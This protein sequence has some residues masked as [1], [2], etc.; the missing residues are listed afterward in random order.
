MG[1]NNGEVN[2]NGNGNSHYDPDDEK[3]PFTEKE[4]VNG[5]DIQTDKRESPHSSVTPRAEEDEG[6]LKKL[7]SDAIYREKYWIS[8]GIMWSFFVLGWTIGQF[9]PSLLDLRIITST[10]LKQASA[11]MTGH[12][13]G[14]LIGSI[15]MGIIFDKMRKEKTFSVAWSVVAMTVVLAVIPWCYIYELMVAMHVFKGLA[16]G[17]LDTTGN[18]LLISLWRADGKSFLQSIHFAFAIGG[19]ISPFVTG[20]FLAP[21]NNTNTN[22][23]SEIIGNT[24]L[25]NYTNNATTSNSG[26]FPWTESRLYVPYSIAAFLALTA[27]VPLFVLACTSKRPSDVKSVKSVSSVD[28]DIDEE[29]N[30]QRLSFGMKATVLIILMVFLGIY[31]AME[32]G[33]NSFLATF[34]VSKLK[35]TKYMASIVTAVFWISYTIARFIGIF[36]ARIFKPVKLIFILTVLVILGFLGFFLSAQFKFYEG[37]WISSGVVGLAMSMIFPLVFAWTE[38]SILPVTGLVASLFLIAASLGSMINPIVLGFLMDNSSP[39]WLAY[40][41]LGESIINLMVLCLAWT[42][43]SRITLPKNTFREVKIEIRSEDPDEIEYRSI[44]AESE[45]NEDRL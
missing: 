31:C 45:L 35:W 25:A 3:T 43:A 4:E 5:N 41:M 22:T 20:P 23:T 19:A 42:V 17:G 24:S 32:D 14:Y 12:S 34:C 30:I 15:V 8:I 27:T 10:S 11:F 36:L 38:E 7:K 18:A 13:V 40:I 39:M 2:K 16:G 29:R 9:G 6:I 28:E 21:E 37:I 26:D 44:I 1:V 33:F